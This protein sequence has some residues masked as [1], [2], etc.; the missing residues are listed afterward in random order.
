MCV[1]GGG[2]WSHYDMIVLIISTQIPLGVH[3]VRQVIFH[4]TIPTPGYHSDILR[5]YWEG[6]RV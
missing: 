2:E 4:S 1:R 6:V 3:H 5:Y